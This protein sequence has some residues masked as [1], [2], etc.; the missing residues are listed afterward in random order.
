MKRAND[1]IHRLWELPMNRGPCL[2]ADL[3]TNLCSL[4]SRMASTRP[5]WP[6][7]DPE[8]RLF[9]PSNHILRFA[10]SGTLV[11]V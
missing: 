8:H 2:F 7:A 1:T 11:S 10:L 5:V 4:F 9:W 3:S 6:H